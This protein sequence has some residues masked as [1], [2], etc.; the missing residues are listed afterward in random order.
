MRVVVRDPEPREVPFAPGE[1]ASSATFAGDLV[2]TV[3][4]GGG[5]D[6][7]ILVVR[8]WRTGAMVTT[9]DLQDGI[10]AIALRP[11]GRAAVITYEGGALRGAPRCVAAAPRR[12][13]GL[14]GGL[15]G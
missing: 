5:E 11:D 1:S 6:S 10:N 13:R 7:T 14:Q 2:A 9:A 12:R 3:R 4:N 8:D 15:R